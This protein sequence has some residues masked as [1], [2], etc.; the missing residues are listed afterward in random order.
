MTDQYLTVW[1][2]AWHKWHTT[3]DDQAA[4]AILRQR[5]VPRV[6]GVEP[7]KHGPREAA[8]LREI[9]KSEARGLDWTA[10]L[11]AIANFLET[12]LYPESVVA[13]LQAQLAEARELI[14][15]AHEVIDAQLEGEFPEL[16]GDM[17]RF[18]SRNVGADQ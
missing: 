18:I 12:P 1:Y 5:F 16:A 10:N 7:V 9:A 14:R 2:T 11:T 13:S 3:F 4:A 8:M 17:Q 6:E 15:D